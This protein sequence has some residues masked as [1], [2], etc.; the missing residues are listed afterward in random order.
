MKLYTE[1]DTAVGVESLAGEVGD[2]YLLMVNYNHGIPDSS[3]LNDNKMTFLLNDEEGSTL[4]FGGVFD[5]TNVVFP[6]EFSV[7]GGSGAFSNV[8]DSVMINTDGNVVMFDVTRTMDKD[9][10]IMNDMGDEDKGSDSSTATNDSTD[11]TSGDGDN[12]STASTVKGSSWLIIGII[13]Y[14][15]L[16]F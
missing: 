15:F 9:D 1:Y 6:Q 4:V 12:E 14:L 13:S 16:W 8:G 11:E 3:Y 10:D 5:E 7:F 2:Y